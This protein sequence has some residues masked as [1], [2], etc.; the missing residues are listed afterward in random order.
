MRK[1]RSVV[2]IVQPIN[3]LHF[4]FVQSIPSTST[5]P[6]RTTTNQKE[7]AF[8][9]G[10]PDDIAQQTPEPKEREV[11]REGGAIP[12]CHICDNCHKTLQRNTPKKVDE[13]QRCI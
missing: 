1:K 8:D 13:P 9:S 3:G 7:I 11:D 6:Y 12:I 5:I 2:R 4:T 10:L